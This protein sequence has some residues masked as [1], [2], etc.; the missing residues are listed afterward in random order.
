M[1]SLFEATFSPL[2]QTGRPLSKC[3]KCTRYMKYIHLKPQRLYCPTC[4]ETYSLPQARA[5]HA[6]MC[7]VGGMDWV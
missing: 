6:H 3:G 4:N 1:D 7:V 2:A 5:M